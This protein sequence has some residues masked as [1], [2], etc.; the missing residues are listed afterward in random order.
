MLGSFSPES[1]SILALVSIC[2]VLEN[3]VKGHTDVKGDIKG[4]EVRGER[5]T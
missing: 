5:V 1:K 4:E 3:A 2:G